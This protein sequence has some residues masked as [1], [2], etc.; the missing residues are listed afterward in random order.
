MTTNV[1]ITVAT[2][3]DVLWVPSQAVFESENRS[4][5]YVDSPKGFVQQDIKLVRRGE[6]QAVITGLAEGTRVALSR[7]DKETSEGDKGNGVMKA[8]TK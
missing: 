6:S 8:L 7:P 4:Y 5:V 1:V 2:L 3:H